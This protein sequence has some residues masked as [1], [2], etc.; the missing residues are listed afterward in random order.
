MKCC[1]G[2]RALYGIHPCEFSRSVSVPHDGAEAPFGS[3]ALISAHS[4]A[5]LMG[6][7]LNR[8]GLPYA[9]PSSGLQDTPGWR[10]LLFSVG[11]SSHTTFGVRQRQRSCRCPL[12]LQYIARRCISSTAVTPG[13][14]NGQPCRQGVVGLVRGNADRRSTP[15]RS[16]RRCTCDRRGWSGGVWVGSGVLQRPPLRG[17]PRFPAPGRTR[18]CNGSL[19]S[20]TCQKRLYRACVMRALL[21][22][23]RQSLSC[24]CRAA[25]GWGRKAAMSSGIGTAHISCEWCACQRYSVRMPLRVAALRCLGVQKPVAS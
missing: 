19:R 20:A 17:R 22:Y 16:L 18:F 11:F 15:W 24:I 4:A 5:E 13:R 12:E 21:S 8:M 23:L 3:A 1:R 14:P 2:D 7:I 10:P 6:E 9:Q 25:C